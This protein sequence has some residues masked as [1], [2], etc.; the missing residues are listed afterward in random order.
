MPT[1]TRPFTPPAHPSLRQLPAQSSALSPTHGRGRLAP[2]TPQLRAVAL[3]QPPS[4]PGAEPQ[5]TRN[6]ARLRRASSYN[7]QAKRARDPRR[8]ATAA[9]PRTHEAPVS[10]P[11]AP[12]VRFALSTATTS[13]SPTQSRWRQP[14][15]APVKT[16][17]DRCFPTPATLHS[18]QPRPASPSVPHHVP[19]HRHHEAPLRVPKARNYLACVCS[20]RKAPRSALV[21]GAT[22]AVASAGSLRPRARRDARPPMPA[23]HER[24]PGDEPSRHH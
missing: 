24:Q 11:P 9:S 12:Y 10:S 20:D 13:A 3:A 2:P 18:A 8:L 5:C 19:G 1:G 21:R 23:R 15:V 6:R 4:P 14:H 7:R 16:M 17:R 22:L